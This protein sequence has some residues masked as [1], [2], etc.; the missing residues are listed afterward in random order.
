MV[1]YVALSTR[2]ELAFHGYPLRRLKSFFGLWGA[3][4]I[5]AFIFA[6]EHVA[7]G[8]TLWL[9]LLGAGVGSLLFGMAAIATRGIA[10]PIGLHAAWNI[11][12]WMRGGKDWAGIWKPVLE[13]GFKDRAAFVGITS[14]VLVTCL[15]TLTFWWWYL[16]HRKA[17][18][19][20]GLTSQ[21]R[22]RL[23]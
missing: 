3:Q 14:Y 19:M 17:Q 11:G 7:G 2:E 12:D 10:L 22:L 4:F 9:A 13:E 23:R 5:V 21:G 1:A 6:L 20:P 15:A 18:S 16:L 8:S